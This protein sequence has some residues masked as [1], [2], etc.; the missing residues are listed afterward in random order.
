MLITMMIN[1]DYDDDD[2]YYYYVACI[3]FL[4]AGFILIDFFLKLWF[5]WSGY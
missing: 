4:Q 2:D 5:I 3:D 1:D